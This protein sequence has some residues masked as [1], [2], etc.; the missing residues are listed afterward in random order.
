M[1]G[2]KNKA[3]ED[4]FLDKEIRTCVNSLREFNQMLTAK[5]E[6]VIIANGVINLYPEGSADRQKAVADAAKAKSSMVNTLANYD[7]LYAVLR[8]L[9]AV[10][11]E[12][13]TTTYWT[14]D[15]WSE[16]HEIVENTYRNFYRK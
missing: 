12:R 2:K 6:K 9:L 5:V 15:R 4:T 3:N 14:I 10:N 16:S 11:D 7:N 13:N 1:S 8:R